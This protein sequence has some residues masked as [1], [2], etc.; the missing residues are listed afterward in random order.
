MHVFKKSLTL[1][2]TPSEA[3]EFFSAPANLPR[4]TPP[5]MDCVITSDLPEKMYPG[6]II[7]YRMKPMLG[8]PVHW[9]SE[10][11]QVREPFFFV[12]DQRVGPY[13]FW[14]HQHAFRPVA[15]GVRC[16][17]VVHYKIPLGPLGRLMDRFFI[18][19]QLQKIFDYREKILLEQFGRYIE[20][21]PAAEG[22]LV[23][24]F[25]PVEWQNRVN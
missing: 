17:D 4:I 2:I 5:R 8:I 21:E 10:I 3:W 12:D 24:H 11:T 7:S 14:H 13:T 6:M 20:S 18:R 9:T 19:S 15:G 23:E 16:E 25:P 1:P 22:V